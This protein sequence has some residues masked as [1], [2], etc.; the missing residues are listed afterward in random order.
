MRGHRGATGVIGVLAAA[1]AV[2]ALSG[3]GPRPGGALAV[4]AENGSLV[5]YLGTCHGT[6]ASA[7]DEVFVYR[8]KTANSTAEAEIS[9][10]INGQ[11]RVVMSAMTDYPDDN[12]Y[13]VRASDGGQSVV[14][15]PISFDPATVKAL[16]P[17]TVWDGTSAIPLEEWL[18]N[19]CPV[20]TNTGTR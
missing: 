9:R 11:R 3:C 10:P 1:V 2:T 8:S 14:A 18:K 13:R 6:D 12:D 17:N 20:S 19:P 4:S 5:A 16:P 7:L 15:G